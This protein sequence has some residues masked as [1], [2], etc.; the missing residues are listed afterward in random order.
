MTPLRQRM[1]EDMEMRNLSPKT[2]QSYVRQVAQFAAHFDKSPDQ[3]GPEE[4]RT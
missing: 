1:L 4:I 2:Q 3:L